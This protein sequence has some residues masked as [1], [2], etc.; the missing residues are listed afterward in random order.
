MEEVT[1]QDIHEVKYKRAELV[2]KYNVKYEND[3][4]I[5]GNDWE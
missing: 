3:I 5:D 4:D 1:F 2:K